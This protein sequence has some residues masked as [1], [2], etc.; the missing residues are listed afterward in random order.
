MLN[1]YICV[2]STILGCDEQKDR[3]LCCG[4]II[5]IR[6][7]VLFQNTHHDVC[8]FSD[9]PSTLV[10]HHLRPAGEGRSGTI[11]SVCQ[12]RLF[13]LNWKDFPSWRVFGIRKA[14]RKNHDDFPE[15]RVPVLG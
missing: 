2:F 1:A 9:V 8:G 14:H 10:F 7:R 15:T 3:C 6:D 5:L 4:L 13:L 12:V 11:L